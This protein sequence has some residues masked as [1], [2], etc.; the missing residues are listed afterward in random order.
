[1]TYDVVNL[2]DYP[3]GAQ[4]LAVPGDLNQLVNWTLLKEALSVL[5]AEPAVH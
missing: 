3:Y 1:L 4:A 2:Q 5:R